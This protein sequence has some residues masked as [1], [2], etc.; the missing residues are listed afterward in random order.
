MKRYAWIETPPPDRGAV[1]ALAAAL[2]I[3]H[4]GARLLVA[5]GLGDPEAAR[6]FLRPDAGLVRDP[7]AFARMVEAVECVQ[8]AVRERAAILVHGDYDVDGISGTALLHQYLHTLT[9]VRRFVPDR[10]RD[11]YGVAERA[12]EWAVGEGVGLFIAVDCGTSDVE[13]IERLLE[14]G[15]DVVV[16][17]HHRPRADG[18][19]A[20]I[21]LNP[22][23]AGETY[24]FDGLCGAG[25]ALKL[26]EALHARGVRGDV[27]PHD[28]LD[29]VALATVGDQ[30]PL[31][32]ENRWYVRAGIERINAAP[33]PGLAAMRRI[34]RYAQRPVDARAIAF[35][36]APRLNA[37]GRVSRP[38]PALELLCA[39]DAQRAMELALRLESD[40][41]T[42]RSLTEAV[43]DAAMRMVE[44]AGDAPAWVL[45]G[46]DWDE[47]VLGIAAAR[48]AE[49][50]G[51][52]A[53][54]MSIQGDVAKGSGR[55]VPGVDLKAHLDRVGDVF[56]RYGG[57][58]QAVGLT[59]RTDRIDD[60]RERFARSLLGDTAATRGLPLRIDAQIA[61][62]E[63]SPELL[64]VLER[65]EPFGVGN[66]EPVFRIADVQ[67]GTR[68]ALVGDGHLKLFFQDTRGVPGEAIAFRW[69]RPVGPEEL[70][71]R[72][73]D[74]AVTIRRSSWSGGDAVDLHVV[75]VAFA[76][77]S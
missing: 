8:R 32:D 10:R 40:N 63:C 16:C 64:D 17:D 76:G 52:P 60:F 28:L 26:V 35:G 39:T 70:A 61:I 36:L 55:S 75:D 49:R 15:I 69:D 77:G 72:V 4:A 58:A 11:G 22:H 66:P 50:T 37:P 45:A 44:Q 9:E 7:F 20:G 33:R 51:R 57:H 56:E 23:R 30:A 12:V 14:A 48:V 25:V 38:R 68:S 74:L 6:R 73:V 29:L 53:V 24:P 1:E 67:V 59:I 46:E 31:V 34:S 41:E 3:P 18:R 62:D 43:H 54:L 47:G 42:R 21:V 71:G 27:E 19:A 5:R 13:R 2:S 65:C